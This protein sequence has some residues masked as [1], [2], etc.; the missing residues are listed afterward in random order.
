MAM[1]TTSKREKIGHL[2]E[3]NIHM[4]DLLAK[5]VVSSKVCHFHLQTRDM[6][7]VSFSF[8]VMCLMLSVC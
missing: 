4:Y 2:V 5:R 7:N 8:S 6:Y 3:A 1:S